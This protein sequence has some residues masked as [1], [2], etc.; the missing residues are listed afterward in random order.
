MQLMLLLYSVR[1]Q[2]TTGV[3]DQLG[4]AGCWIFSDDIL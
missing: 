2:I 3:S 1:E 4:Q